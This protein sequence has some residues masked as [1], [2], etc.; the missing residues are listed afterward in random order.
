MIKLSIALSH[1]GFG[2]GGW[3]LRSGGRES[4]R[5]CLASAR[6]DFEQWLSMVGIE[7]VVDCRG[8]VAT[9]RNWHTVHTNDPAKRYPDL[10]GACPQK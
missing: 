6:P 5:V 2:Y 1:V 8:E 10:A 9:K 7:C 3:G 4:I